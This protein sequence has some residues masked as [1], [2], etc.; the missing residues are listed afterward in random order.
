MKDLW[1]KDA[2][3]YCLDIETYQDSNGDGSG[4]FAELIQR[5]NYI[6]NFG[7]T[8]LWVLPFY[9]SPNR[10]NGYDVVDL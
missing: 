1:Y 9:V 6:A 8:S 3:I 7:V 2:I 10:D 5:L 4:G